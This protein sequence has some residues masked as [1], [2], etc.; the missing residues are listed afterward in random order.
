[1]SDSQKQPAATIASIDH[2]IESSR[3]ILYVREWTPS[4][5]GLD[6][7]ATILMFHDSLGCVELWRDFPQQLAAMTGRRVVA[8]DRVGFG[9]SDPHR[10]ALPVTFIRDEAVDVV[11]RLREALQLDQIVAFGHSVGGAMAVATAASLPD[12]CVA[13]VTVSAQS[14]IEDQTLAGIRVAQADFERPGQFERLARYH[15][16]KARWVLDSWITTWLSPA[17]AGW[18]LDDELQ[19]VHCPVL[20]FHGDRDEYGSAQH[21]ERIARLAQGASRAVIL[22]DCGHVPHRE[23]PARVLTEVVRF[24]AFGY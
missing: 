21:A 17:F 11:P 6:D 18:R 3:G 2:W 23:Q 13:V 4:D 15:G 14:F 16:T 7:A 24:L 22:E 19:R 9:R 10:G 12:A 8:Y 1:M 20:A 5:L